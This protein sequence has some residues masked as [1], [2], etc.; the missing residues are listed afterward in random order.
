VP[1]EQT[2][3]GVLVLIACQT[4][5]HIIC[6]QL[7]IDPRTFKKA[8]KNEIATGQPRALAVVSTKLFQLAQA[9]NVGAIA[10][11]YRYWGG[12]TVNQRTGS[13][14]LE[15]AAAAATLAAMSASGGGVESLA[16]R[17]YIPPNNRDNPPGEGV[18]P[19]IDGETE[20]DAEIDAIS[21]ST[22][23]AA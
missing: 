5:H 22:E 12:P 16:P 3:Q 19:V 4:P 20:A 21:A 23:E 1:D 2:R 11:W 15:E 10:L 13:G 18:G 6:D 8:F 7:R 9:G 17:V 14:S